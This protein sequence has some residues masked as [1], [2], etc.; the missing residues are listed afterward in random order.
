MDKKKLLK[1][2]INRINELIGNHNALNEDFSINESN[3]IVE[4]LTGLLLDAA[5][6]IDNFKKSAAKKS[7]NLLDYMDDFAKS[8]TD[9]D[10]LIALSKMMDESDEFFKVI[11]PKIRKVNS[12][13]LGTL[14]KLVTDALKQGKDPK[15]I[16]AVA[17]AQINK[18]FKDIPSNKLKNEL[19][20]DFDSIVDSY[21]PGAF[22]NVLIPS[23]LQ[24]KFKNWLSTSFPNLDTVQIG[25]AHV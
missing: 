25:R 1:E 7:Q 16:K 21:K 22:D 8:T 14:E 5:K 24:T 10:K 19:V 20:S 4:S 12:L 18:I 13:Q 3:L 6:V 9:A 15:T 17:K 23:G 11:L 2:E